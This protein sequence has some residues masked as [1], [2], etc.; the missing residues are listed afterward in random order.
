MGVGEATRGRAES[1]A[2][3]TPTVGTQEHLRW[4]W[5]QE[6][7]RLVPGGLGV[8]EL[9]KG[10]WSAP[11][12]AAEKGL[13]APGL[14]A[15]RSPASCSPSSS[16]L[17]CPPITHKSFCPSLLSVSPSLL[18]LSSLPVRPRVGMGA[19]AQLGLDKPPLAPALGCYRD[20][21]GRGGEGRKGQR[22]P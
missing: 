10:V 8:Q 17:L 20:G 11:L 1:G 12:S 4:E 18:L 14:A 16:A 15:P 9:L 2:L 21:S 13:T 22:W 7:L 3:G 5:N 19:S 6:N